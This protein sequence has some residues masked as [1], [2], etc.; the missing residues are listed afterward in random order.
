[1]VEQPL[2]CFHQKK[3]MNEIHGHVRN[4][5]GSHLQGREGGRGSS[6]DQEG[7]R[8]NRGGRCRRGHLAQGK[9]RR[10]FFP[11]SQLIASL[12]MSEGRA[13]NR[14]PF[15]F[16]KSIAQ[17]PG[18]TTPQPVR[19][20]LIRLFYGAMVQPLHVAIF[21]PLP[22]V[23]FLAVSWRLRARSK[24]DL[25]IRRYERRLTLGRYQG[26]AERKPVYKSSWRQ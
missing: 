15:C 3:A 22:S 21:I 17:G 14:A 12:S 10:G 24:S 11:T 26:I 16:A 19:K 18:N 8:E 25:P 13:G 20:G 9:R 5:T 2:G 23:G 7:S 6:E 1:V 4:R